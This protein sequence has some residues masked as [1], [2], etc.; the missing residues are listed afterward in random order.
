M[1]F[2]RSP[3][4]LALAISLIGSLVACTEKVVVPADSDDEK[5]S[6]PKGTT[7]PPSK[8]TAKPGTSKPKPSADPVNDAKPTTCSAMV[9][10]LGE[11]EGEEDECTDKCYGALP[12]DELKELQ[13]ISLCIADSGCTDDECV[14]ETCAT[15]IE[16]CLAD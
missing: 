11:C 16:T 13:A 9:E 8:E 6:S 4:Q 5:D 2:M 10:C 15:Q 14:A 1:R 3:K 12:D 7:E